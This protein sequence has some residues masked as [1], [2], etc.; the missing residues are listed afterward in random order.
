M[1]ALE[2]ATDEKPGSETDPHTTSENDPDL[3]WSWYCVPATYKSIVKGR[4]RRRHLW[5]RMYLLFQAP[6]NRRPQSLTQKATAVAQ[7]KEHDNWV[8]QEVEVDEMRELFDNEMKEGTEVYW[9][10]FERVDRT[11]S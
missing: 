9:D 4:P 5:Q 10:F 11:P 6:C 2:T 1:S 7:S 3:Q 8:L